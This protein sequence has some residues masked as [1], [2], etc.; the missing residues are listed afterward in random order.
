MATSVHRIYREAIDPS[1]TLLR[2]VDMR[3]GI[4]SLL[5]FVCLMLSIAP[6]LLCSC[7]VLLFLACYGVYRRILRDPVSD[8]IH[9]LALLLHGVVESVACDAYAGEPAGNSKCNAQATL[10]QHW[11]YQGNHVR[12]MWW[13]ACR[14]QNCA[15]D[16]RFRRVPKRALARL[17]SAHH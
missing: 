9:P 1:I 12:S 8:L 2:A 14:L 3:C 11:S 5:S 15:A 10:N 4:R 17:R 7:Q 13:H 16:S 6:P